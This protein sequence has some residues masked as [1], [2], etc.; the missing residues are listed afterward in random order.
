M[1][2]ISVVIEYDPDAKTYGA[3]SPDLPDIYAV[4]D[5]RED[6]LDRFTKSVNEY[7]TYLRE[8]GEP[9]PSLTTRHEVVTIA[10]PAA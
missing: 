1:K 9:L 8:Q 3:T 5:S 4:S 7:I 6:V 10:I 2:T